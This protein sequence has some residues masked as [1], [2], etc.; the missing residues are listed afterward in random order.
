MADY[1]EQQSG[2][3]CQQAAGAKRQ[4]AVELVAARSVSLTHRRNG[5]STTFVLLND[6]SKR[7]VFV[8]AASVPVFAVLLLAG[9]GVFLAEGSVHPPHLIPAAEVDHLVDAIA[10]EDAADIRTVFLTAPDGTR[11]HA[12]WLRPRRG[13]NRGVLIAHGVGDSAWGSA[14]YSRMF[15]LRGYS[16]LLP[17]SRGHGQS[18]GLVTYGLREASDVRLWLKWMR[19]VGGADQMYGLG[20]SLG[21]SILLDSLAPGADFK[22]ADFK[23]VVAECAYSSFPSIATERAGSVL[24]TVGLL[25]T[26]LRYH[27]DLTVEPQPIDAVAKTRVPIL[28]I[29][30]LADWRTSP[31]NS[32]RIARAGKNVEIWLVPGAGH[33]S[34]YAVS[35]AEF[36]DKVLGWFDRASPPQVP[37]Q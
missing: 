20:E 26:R 23:A 35:P 14:G 21:A 13:G 29:H 10:N 6:V 24:T 16:V 11:L 31:Q 4:R 37:A 25:Y 7:T 2:V 5:L 8:F 19:E 28:L 17:E 3:H 30:G 32:L 36:E 18:D 9:G 27:V 34:A 33:V 15:L 1:N 22:A 12:Y